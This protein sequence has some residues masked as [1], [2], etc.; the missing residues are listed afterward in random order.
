MATL[1]AT[2]RADTERIHGEQRVL[3]RLL[4]E[5]DRALDRLV[6]YGEVFADFKAA[7]QIRR[8]GRQLTEQ[9]PEHCQREEAQLL[10]PVAG[11]SPELAEFC[12]RMKGEHSDLLV[13]LA[14]FRKA[15]DDFDRTD[16]LSEAICAL[17][18]RGKELTRDL[19][20]H[21]ENEEQELSRFL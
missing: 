9:F 12:S 6:Y 19:R 2:F 8:Y 18:D 21:V 1:S 13:Q 10:D 17:K 5:L 4:R 16:D 20:R 14:A 7:G 11:V 3:E 15:L